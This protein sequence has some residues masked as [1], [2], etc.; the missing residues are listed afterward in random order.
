MAIPIKA[1]LKLSSKAFNL[2]MK[3][4]NKAVGGLVFALKAV[5]LAIPVV[6]GLFT[7]LIARQSALIDRVGK[8]SQTTGIAVGTLQKFGF[9]AELA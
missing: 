1:T 4:A 6:T 9:A 5:A 7:A 8:V 2:G 3:A